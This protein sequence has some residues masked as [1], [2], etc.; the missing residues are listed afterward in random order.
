MRV[1]EREEKGKCSKQTSLALF[2]L[3]SQ[4]NASLNFAMVIPNPVWNLQQPNASCHATQANILKEQ[5]WMLSRGQTRII[6]GSTAR[7]EPS[8]PP[9]DQYHDS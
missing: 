7:P 3:A 8:L 1:R 6:L 2:R 4:M 5:K 9:S